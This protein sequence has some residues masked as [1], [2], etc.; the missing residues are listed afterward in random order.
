M[1]IAHSVFSVSS[2]IIDISCED[3][4]VSDVSVNLVSKAHSVSTDLSLL[5]L[6]SAIT[7]LN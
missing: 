4:V 7:S 3:T 2:S 5:L 6:M 1:V